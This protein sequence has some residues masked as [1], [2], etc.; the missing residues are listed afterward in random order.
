M[1]KRKKDIKL[2][3]K[4]KTKSKIKLEKKQKTKSKIKLEK[5][6]KT[7]NKIK[8]EKKQKI[9]SKN[10]ES[11]SKKNQNQNQSQRGVPFFRSIQ[12][13]LI[14]AFMIPV[15]SIIVLGVASYYNAS[16]AVV[17]SYEDSAGQTMDMMKN[18]L[19]LAL[20]TI[21]S[22]YK[23]Y[24]N[25]T[26]LTN[27]LGGYYDNDNIKR[28]QTYNSFSTT[29]GKAVTADQLISNIFILSYNEDS[30]TTSQTS[31]QGLYDTYA[32]TDQGQLIV[33]DKYNYYWFGNQ[34]DADEALRTDSG[35]YGIRLARHFNT[36]K[37]IML[38][39][40]DISVLMNT[41]DSLDVGEDGYIGLVTSDGTEVMSD[42]SE[43]LG[44]AVFI[45]KDF[46]ADAKA[47]EDAE[48]SQYVTY[49]GQE[50]LFLYNKLDG[51]DAMIC[52]LISK[53][54]ITRQTADIKQLTVFIVLISCVIA[55]VLAS[56]FANGIGKTIGL[57]NKKLKQVSGGDLTVQVETKRKDEFKLLA[58]GI[59]NMIF[60]MRE[61][62]SDVN[63]VSGELTTAVAKVY[64]S[65]QTFMKSS[66]EIQGAISEIQNGIT[67]LDT[68]SADCLVQMDSLSGKIGLV[69]DSTAQISSM[70]SATGASINQGID[71]MSALN[72]STRS[73]AKITS[74][75]IEAITNLELKSRSIGQIVN[76]INEIAEQTNLLS[77]NA[78]IEAARSGEA[79]KGFVVVADEIRKLADQSLA[80]ANKIQN[81]IDEII[82]NTHEVVNTASQA[83]DVVELQENAVGFTTT[84]FHEMDEQV[85]YL[86]ES[87]DSILMNVENMQQA[88]NTT[89]GAIESI[90]AFSAET[91][92]CSSSVAD[93][94]DR[95]L[96]A[97]SNLDQAAVALSNRAEA[98][99]EM[100]QKFT[101]F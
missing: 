44:E 10:K 31:D 23:G 24:L 61:I 79:G 99:T 101:V 72:Q 91:A 53:D 82:E 11:K 69:T 1:Q 70:T 54:N 30:F 76:V 35:E 9:K 14:M 40:V 6:Q 56:F 80:S 96:E 62:V 83:K 67:Q 94:A 73:T 25:E 87:L 66:Q 89:L 29:F 57:I 39:D 77:L 36:S 41:L 55:I 33:N 68:N 45:D 28:S 49:K 81:I 63:E 3:K 64:D 51:R 34:S 100:L 26:E 75:V 85:S 86:M 21:Q 7:K 92:A 48:G 60:H 93:I 98:L 65:S 59:N 47:S 74:D 20:D 90:S 52:A 8:L 88:K 95:Q 2:E 58:E 4:Q 84:S 13:K 17:K 78:S 19:N 12:V 46:Y 97:I 18:Y 42:T 27:Y 32:A 43:E 50:Y 22:N 15:C 16:S 71:S 37:T 38:V 5:K